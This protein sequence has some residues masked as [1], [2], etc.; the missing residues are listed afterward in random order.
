MVC[1]SLPDILEEFYH[2]S[3]D[4]YFYYGRLY[5]IVRALIV[6]DILVLLTAFLM[7]KKQYERRTFHLYLG[8]IFVL[9]FTAVA[10][11]V[12]DAWY[13]QNM[14]IFFSSMI[15]FFRQ[16]DTGFRSVAGCKGRTAAFRVPGES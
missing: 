7:S 4:N 11:Y 16:H 6:L 15:I 5:D 2:F 13:L 3:S 1:I 9:Q 10:D 14:A 8:Y 12:I